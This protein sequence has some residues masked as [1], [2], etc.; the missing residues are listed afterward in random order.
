MGSAGFVERGFW[1][2][3]RPARPPQ[4]PSRRDGR[5]TSGKPGGKGR[6]ALPT[7]AAPTGPAPDAA[8]TSFRRLCQL[9]Q[10]SDAVGRG[11]P[12]DGGEVAGECSPLVPYDNNSLWQQLN[13]LM[14]VNLKLNLA[15]FRDWA[16]GKFQR[17]SRRRSTR[18]NHDSDRWCHSELPAFLNPRSR[19]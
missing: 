15:P 2:R 13:K 5:A 6:V 4:P 1:R 9:S 3:A 17:S 16:F 8:P 18:C 7:Y 19:I 14:N 12:G 10:E 11:P